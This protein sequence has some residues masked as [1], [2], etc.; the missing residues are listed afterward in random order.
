MLNYTVKVDGYEEDEK[1]IYFKLRI[2]DMIQMEA[3]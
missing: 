2:T 1:N 3:R